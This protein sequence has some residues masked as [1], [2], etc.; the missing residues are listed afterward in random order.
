RTDIF[1]VF[2]IYSVNTKK[3][4]YDA[5]YAH[6]AKKLMK[7]YSWLYIVRNIFLWMIIGI[8]FM[9][10]FKYISGDSSKYFFHA[11]LMMG[12]P[13][14]IFLLI[15]NVINQKLVKCFHPSPEGIMLGSKQF[16]IT[17][18]GIKETHLYGYNFYKW[19][20]V[21]S[22]EEI[23]GTVYVYVDRVLALIFTPESF[24][25]TDSKKELVTVVKKYV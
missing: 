5:F 14:F 4:D 12:V 11:V 2:L 23:N 19:T 7:P 8:F 17:E 15:S 25:S 13:F 24:E 22:I 1:G 16:E 21:N 10:L 9:S 6:V 20:V 18:D 3:A